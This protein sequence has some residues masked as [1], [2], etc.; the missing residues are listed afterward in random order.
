MLTEGV[1]RVSVLSCLVDILTCQEAS[2]HEHFFPIVLAGLLGIRPNV[3][4]DEEYAELLK[5]ERGFFF[6][7]LSFS[8]S[9]LPPHSLTYSPV[10]LK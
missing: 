10:T 1:S 2:D 7:S 5:R 4:H 6:L 3:H 9:L 8:L